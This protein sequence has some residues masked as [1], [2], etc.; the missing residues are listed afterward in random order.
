MTPAP[1]PPNNA[2]VARIWLATVGVLVFLRYRGEIGFIRAYHRWMIDHDVPRWARSFDVDIVLLLSGVALWAWLRKGCGARSGLLN[3]L[4]VSRDVASGCLAGLV[5]G[6]PMLGLAAVVG[7]VSFEPR[8]VR[9]VLTGPFTEEW[10][11]RGLLVLACVRLARVRFWPL[12]ILGGV[13]FGAVHVQWT[14]SGVASGWL[15]GF[16]TLAGGIWYAWLARVWGHNLWV[17]IVAHMTMNLSSPW[18]GPDN[19]LWLEIGR[20]GTI[21][22]GTVWAVRRMGAAD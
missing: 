19:G 22:L 14:A 11:F 20:L 18:Y 21:A 12:A 9:I 3:D 13:L 8:F 2:L 4:G 1:A 5:I 17:P 16:V 7:S 10:F 6:A 15:H